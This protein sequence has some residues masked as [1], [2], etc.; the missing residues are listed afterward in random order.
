MMEV[1]MTG[2]RHFAVV[3]ASG[4][5]LSIGAGCA[6]E[7]EAVSPNAIKEV[8]GNKNLNFQAP[9]DGRITVYDSDTD[10]IAYASEIRKGEA[11]TVDSDNNRISLNGQTAV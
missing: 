11:L 7:S 4:I 6:H 3:A 2:F 10:H 8:E 5:L 9:N 1:F